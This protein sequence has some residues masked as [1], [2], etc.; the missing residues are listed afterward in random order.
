MP[1]PLAVA[2]TLCLVAAPVAAQDTTSVTPAR[3]NASD[4]QPA[5]NVVV[6]Y[7]GTPSSSDPA[8]ASER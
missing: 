2:F 1:R 6:D 7:T 3:P 5:G 4:A 8:H